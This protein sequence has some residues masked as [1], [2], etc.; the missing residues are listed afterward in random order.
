MRDAPYGYCQ[1]GC[2]QK[3]PVAPKN[4]AKRGYVKG[5]PK[6]FC[7][8]HGGRRPVA[9][10]FWEKVDRRGPDECW[11]WTAAT[12]GHGYGMFAVA[13]VD[14]R[15][16]LR[17]AH[18]MAYELAVGPIPEGLEID[19]TCSVRNCVNPAHLEPVTHLENC[20]RTVRRGR[21]RWRKE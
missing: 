21:G 7:Q 16:I 15:V 9:E 2:G 5:E 18:R 4:N 1:C 13:K 19:H 3:A 8:G 11:P 17:Q 20:R 14:G 10:R 12:K 6:R